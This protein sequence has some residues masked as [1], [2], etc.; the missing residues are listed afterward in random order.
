MKILFICH[1]VPFPANRGGKIRPFNMIRH[2]NRNHHVTVASLAGSEDE[3]R[4]SAGLSDHCAEVIV[5]ILPR[6]V[7]YAQAASA[8]LSRRPSSVAYFHSRRLHQ[9]VQRAAATTRFDVVMVHCAFVAPYALGV[10][11][12]VRILDYGDLDSAKWFDYSRHRGWPISWG[13][14]LEARKLRAFERMLAGR[15]QHCTL[16][17]DGEALEFQTLGVPVPV[18]VIPN[19]VDT[20]YFERRA[21]P[22]DSSLIVFVGRMDYFPNIQGVDYFAREIFPLIRRRLPSAEFRIVGSN[23]SQGTEALA[24]LPGVSVTGHVPDVRPVVENAAVS[25]APLRIAR[26][27]QNKVLESMAMG[28]PVVA[29]REAARGIS[30]LPG[31]HLLVADDP[32][33]FADRVLEVIQSPPLQ[34]RLVDAARERVEY[35][36]AWPRS[37]NKLEALLHESVSRPQPS[38]PR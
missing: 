25:V 8:L 15:V 38:L 10:D 7:R 27:T 19:G 30:A 36:H 11:G 18:T 34:R 1:R 23:P 20:G 21:L 32:A 35:A 28:I 2:L 4:Q 29:T 13:Y 16:T 14:A 31:E 26:G 5:E 22:R 9:R 17:T 33:S 37:M 24:R 12:G 6:R 3:L